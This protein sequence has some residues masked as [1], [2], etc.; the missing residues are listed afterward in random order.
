LTETSLKCIGIHMVASAESRAIDALGGRCTAKTCRWQNDDGK[1]GGCSD[2]RALQ[3][4]HTQDGG[5]AARRD[6]KDSKRLNAFEI[7]RYIRRGW[8]PRFELLCANCHAIESKRRQQGSRLHLRPAR[9]RRSQQK[10]GEPTRR[11]REK[12]EIE[13]ER[14][15][16]DAMKQKTAE[17][18]LLR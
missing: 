17:D 8:P 18:R 13:A 4:H 2:R 12:A 15:F 16:R 1:F 7:L 5:S 6:G 3:F 10:E 14:R 9:I 11:V